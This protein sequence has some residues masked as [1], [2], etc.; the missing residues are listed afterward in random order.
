MKCITVTLMLVVIPAILLAHGNEKHSKGNK[1]VEGASSQ[2]ETMQQK[3]TGH[4]AF[5]NK[6]YQSD[7][8]GIFKQKC[9][10]CHG[11]P[12]QYPW[13]Y[14]VPGI[15]QIM[16]YDIREAKKHLEM[17]KGFPFGGHGD[18]ASDL[19]SLKKS[20]N[21]GSM[22][23]LRYWIVQPGTRLNSHD[24]EVIIR[25]IDQSLDRLEN[26]GAE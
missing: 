11:T 8:K 19:K 3:M 13:Y 5:I 18:P 15:K 16:D 23:P 10:D 21:K 2:M 14:A 20:V 7:V 22:P 24:K 9:F 26:H 17:S 25:W 6:K 4:L 1:S 12:D